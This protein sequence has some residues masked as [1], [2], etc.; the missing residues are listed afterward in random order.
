LGH[1]QV[2][3]EEFPDP[4]PGAG[5][6]LVEI[7][8]SGLCGS[9]LHG[10]RGDHAAAMNGGHEG[11]GIVREANGTHV[12]KPGDRVGIHAVM[13]CGHCRWCAV[14][15]Y[16]FCDGKRGCPP[17]HSQR[18]AVPEHVCLTLDEDIPFDIGVLLSGDGLGVPYHASR[19]LNTCGGEVVCVIGAGPIGLGNVLVQSFLGAEV[20]AVDVD[21]ERLRLAST[22]GAA[23]VVNPR[24]RDPREA[25]AEITRGRLADKCIDCTPRPETTQ[26]A[27]QCVG[28]AGTVLVVGEKG[29]VM[30]S[31]SEDLIRRDITLMGSWFY[32]YAEFPAMVDLYR[33]GL[34]VA[35]LI[36]H[37]FPLEQAAEA[38]AT[39]AGGGTGKVILQG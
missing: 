29:G 32:H 9:E 4:V 17:L 7:Q 10:Y 13:G 26:T 37:H 12:L 19:R 36:T 31:P 18:A 8:A 11:A 1:Q 25:V 34:R 39:F 33:R 14:G 30:I 6:V 5:E 38:F 16:T 3:V 23:H 15:Q 35:D 20:I 22:L 21:E 24:Q 27:L 2:A 28:K